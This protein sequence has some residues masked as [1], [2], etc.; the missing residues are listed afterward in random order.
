M[1]LI[2]YTLRIPRTRLYLR[3]Q[4]GSVMYTR[5][6][7]FLVLPVLL[8]VEKM[9]DYYKTKKIRKMLLRIFSPGVTIAKLYQKVFM[10]VAY[11]Y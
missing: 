2:C 9:E 5:L 8:P 6:F 11:R 1:H 4:K 10:T 3:I 7:Y